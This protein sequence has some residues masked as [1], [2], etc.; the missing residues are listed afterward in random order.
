MFLRIQ[1]IDF[2]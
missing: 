2:L 1:Q